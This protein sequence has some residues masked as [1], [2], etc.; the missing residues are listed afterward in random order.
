[1]K[2][3]FLGSSWL[4]SGLVSS[5]VL[6]NGPLEGIIETLPQFFQI[7]VQNT[8]KGLAETKAFPAEICER[9]ICSSPGLFPS[10]D[11]LCASTFCQCDN[12]G[13]GKLMQCAQG[14]HFD[15][16]TQTCISKPCDPGSTVCLTKACVK[17]AAELIE[18][19]D[20]SMDPCSDFYQFACGGFIEKTV[21]PEHKT[22][23]GPFSL[24]A[25]KLNERL[26]KLF[27]TESDEKE[28][29]VYG[30]VRNLYQ[31][32]MDEET[33]EKNSLVELQQLIDQ[34]GGWPVLQGAEWNGGENWNWWNLSMTASELGYSSNQMIDI[35]IV[36]DSEDSSL[37]RLRVDQPHLGLSREYLIKGVEDKDVQAYYQ[38]MVDTAVFLGAEQ[39]VAEHE[40]KKALEFE[41]KLAEISLP[42]EE[43]RNETA[44]YN[45][46]TIREAQNIYPVLPWVE[47]IN[48]IL[49]P[50]R[51]VTVD[52]DEIVIIAVPQ[53][54]NEFKNFIDSVEPRVIANYIVWRNIEYSMSFLGEEASNI[55]LKYKEVITGT[56]RESPRWEKCVKSTAGLDNHLELYQ[57]EGSLSNAVGAMFAK[58]FFK[59]H[60]KEVAD[61]IIENIRSEFRIILDELDW[62]DDETR[63]KAHKKLDKI[64]AHIAYPAQILDDDLMN[65]FYNGFTL[66]PD[67]YLRN[68]LALNKWISSYQAKEFRNPIDKTSW[69][70]HGGAALVNAFYSP[71][72]NS[73]IFPAGILDGVFFGEGRP[74]YIN[75]GA[76]GYVV[77]HE[78]THGFDD[79]G[80]QKD[81]DGNLVDWWEPETKE[82]YLEKAQCIIDQYGNYTVQVDGEILNLNGIN[83][84][85]ENI[86]DNGGDKIAYRAYSR[87]VDKYGPEPLLPSLPYTQHQLFWL[88]TAQ[89]WCDARKP[90]SLKNQVLTDPHAPGKFR[91]NGPLSNIPEFSQDW[92]CP[93]GTP[94]NPAKKCSVW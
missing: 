46:M 41:L 18:A 27:E 63:E 35:G 52:E 12:F 24:L 78:I 67:S 92:G 23:E 5:S 33:V 10:G 58:K 62:M 65:E 82:R 68:M 84:Q 83:S 81:G 93:K 79:Q 71:E 34:L 59:L 73:I 76:I 57:K 21:I 74:L 39:Q 54:L 51:K 14:T 15:D 66:M 13:K 89:T 31:S 77:G 36:T 28:P 3:Y 70:T 94:M 42:R 44:L 32:C 38:Y 16:Q 47:Y 11:G 64:V 45:P 9:H 69:K 40:M 75:Y 43:R 8:D 48:V 49:D 86:A 6:P 50:Q 37:R 80:S 61:E 72:E 17:T 1:M 7:K 53:Y 2:L 56:S 87:L 55:R 85:G 88:S 91:I 20:E 22:N 19:M 90:A 29:S 4:V 30:S 60:A 25:D 26:R